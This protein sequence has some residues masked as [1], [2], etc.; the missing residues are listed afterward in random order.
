MNVPFS[1]ERVSIWKLARF[2]KGAKLLK[3][4]V[5]KLREQKGDFAV[6]H[7]WGLLF[8]VAVALAVISVLGAVSDSNDLDT[9]ASDLTRQIEIAGQVNYS[10]VNA[11]LAELSAA[12]GLEN[13]TVS[14]DANYLDA[15]T[16][17]IQFGDDF[18][19]TLSYT[20]YLDFGGVISIPVPLNSSVVG[21]SERYWKS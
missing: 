12:A 7:A 6:E 21:R 19:V 18:I 4:A 17:K 11:Q 14:I 1:L 5:D 13:V 10:D 9:I 16:R 3:N 8:A 2:R 20:A 15:G